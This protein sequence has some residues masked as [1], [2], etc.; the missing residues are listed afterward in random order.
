M[1]E[2]GSATT[3]SFALRALNRDEPTLRGRFLSV[4]GVAFLLIAALQVTTGNMTTAA[5]DTAIGALAVWASE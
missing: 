5:V 3:K 2:T 4:L 1:A